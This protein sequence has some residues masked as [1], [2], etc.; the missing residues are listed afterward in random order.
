MA[1]HAQGGGG[2]GGAGP[3]GRGYVRARIEPHDA[4]EDVRRV[5]ARRDV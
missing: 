5:R 2:G 1:T 3:H 4:G